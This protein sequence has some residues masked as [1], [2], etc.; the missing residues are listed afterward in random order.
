[1]FD[2][3][4]QTYFQCKK[5]PCISKTTGLLQILGAGGLIPLYVSRLLVR[6]KINLQVTSLHQIIRF[7]AGPGTRRV[8]VSVVPQYQVKLVQHSFHH[9]ESVSL[10]H[11]SI[12]INNH[13]WDWKCLTFRTVLVHFPSLSSNFLTAKFTTA[14]FCFSSLVQPGHEGRSP[15]GGL[16]I[17]KGEYNLS[18]NWGLIIFIIMFI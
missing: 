4:E 1:M 8:R 5:S 2:D 9:L 7:A 3:K 15:K 18:R 10:Q 16:Y 11:G 6:K 12:D 13:T 14:G 17:S